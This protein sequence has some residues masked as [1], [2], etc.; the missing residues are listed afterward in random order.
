MSGHTVDRCYKLHGHPSTLKG[1]KGKRVAA[2]VYGDEDDDDHVT[3]PTHLTTDQYHKLVQ[4]VQSPSTSNTTTSQ[5]AQNLVH[6]NPTSAYVAG[7]FL[8]SCSNYNKWIVDSG[9]TN[10]ICSNIDMFDS[11]EQFTENRKIL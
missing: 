8:I 5:N 10:H 1:G 2:I 4:S 3:E 11:Y 7:T 9:A 6:S